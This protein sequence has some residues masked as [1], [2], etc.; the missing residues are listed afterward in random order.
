MDKCLLYSIE[1]PMGR[2]EGGGEGPSLVE[3]SKVFEKKFILL[4]IM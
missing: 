2:G 4:R 1:E 3:G